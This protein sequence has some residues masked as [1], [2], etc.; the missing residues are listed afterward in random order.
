M[1]RAHDTHD[2]HADGQPAVARSRGR[3]VAAVAVLERAVEPVVED[4]GF[5]LILLEWLGAGK[6]RVM[7]LYLDH[8][9]GVSI[10]DCSRLSRIVGN[11]LDA[12]EA[13]AV[14]SELTRLLAQPYTL[15]V[16]SP[17]V[18]RPL[19][20]LRHFAAEVGSL[21]KLE[22]WEPLDADDD[23]RKFQGRIVAVEVD[24]AAPDDQH[25]GVV[26]LHDTERDLALHIPLPRIRRA[27]LVWEG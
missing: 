27:N 25:G 17:G 18:D 6:R 8:P 23:R 19:T 13:A 26:T 20:R 15:E 14:D 4:M 5:E 3:H 9:D 12:S 21:V 10:A 16:S 1:T 2:T 22:T 24:T 11:A 7:R